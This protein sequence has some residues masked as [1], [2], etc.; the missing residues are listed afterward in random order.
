M[1]NKIAVVCEVSG[2]GDHLLTLAV[3][4]Q[5]RIDGHHVTVVVAVK[6][7]TQGSPA[8]RTTDLIQWTEAFECWDAIADHPPSGV[9]VFYPHRGPYPPKLSRWR[10]YAAV[11]GLDEATLPRPKRVVPN[12][13]HERAVVLAPFTHGDLTRHW[14]IEDWLELERR[15]I[16][17]GSSVLVVDGRLDRLAPFKSPKYT[18]RIPQEVIDTAL[19]SACLVG[20]DTGLTHLW[21]LLGKP[22][23]VVMADKIRDGWMGYD[24]YPDVCVLGNPGQPAASV[25]QVLRQLKRQIP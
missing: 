22:I 25:D 6:D 19:A 14:R 15:L 9:R 23:V 4:N 24:L 20:V 12:P 1:T 21:G 13:A 16:Q 3:A 10:S 8:D 17:Q 2:L 5:F 11:C 7:R 18:S